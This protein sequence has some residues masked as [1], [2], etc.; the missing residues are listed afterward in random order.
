MVSE[1]LVPSSCTHGSMRAA[2]NNLTAEVDA[3]GEADWHNLS[4]DFADSSIYQTWPYGIARSGRT[5]ISHLVVRRGPDVVAAAQARLTLIPYLNL[6]MAYVFWGPL[7]RRRN[8]QADPEVFRQAVRALK[9][10]YV[11]GRKMVVRIIP[12]SPETINE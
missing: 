3:V 11:G 5:R 8:G 2:D 6:G 7:W 12:N 4:S 9:D 1:A 10:E